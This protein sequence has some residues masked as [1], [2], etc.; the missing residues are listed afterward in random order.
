M[1]SSVELEAADLV[2]RAEAVL[3][4]ADQPQRRVPVALE[5]QHHVDEV[6]EQ[7]RAG[8]RAVLGDVADEDGRDA[9]VLATG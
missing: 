7:P 1:P 6:L 8:D 4:R 2:G 3:D 5:V 9:A